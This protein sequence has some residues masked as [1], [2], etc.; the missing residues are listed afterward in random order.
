MFEAVQQ[1]SISHH[2]VAPY[3]P[4]PLKQWRPA[5]NFCNCYGATLD[6]CAYMFHIHHM[7]FLRSDY[8]YGDPAEQS[9]HLDEPLI[10]ELRAYLYAI[11]S[12][13]TE[14]IDICPFYKGPHFHLHVM[15]VTYF[16]RQMADG[17]PLRVTQQMFL[18]VSADTK[19]WPT[20]GHLKP[21]IVGGGHYEDHGHDD[22]RNR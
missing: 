4:A 3:R 18:T 15:A 11:P 20:R 6:T 13:I 7:F 1:P 17:D 8:K 2:N 21:R 5:A 16:V 9:E 10:A 14:T 19:T 12:E 22:F